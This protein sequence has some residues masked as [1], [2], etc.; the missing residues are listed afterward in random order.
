[1]GW[2]SSPAPQW[3]RGEPPL[4]TLTLYSAMLGHNLGSNRRPLS[5]PAQ[6]KIWEID[7]PFSGNSYTDP[8][9]QSP[10]FRITIQGPGYFHIGSDKCNHTI[11]KSLLSYIYNLYSIFKDFIQKNKIKIISLRFEER[12]EEGSNSTR[13]IFGGFKQRQRYIWCKSRDLPLSTAFLF[14]SLPIVWL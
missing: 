2:A 1:M 14:G 3:H 13:K 8:S 7:E 6:T 11:I 5:A 12:E 10:D 4:Y 9:L